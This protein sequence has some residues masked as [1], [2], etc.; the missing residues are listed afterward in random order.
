MTT[1]TVRNPSNPRAFALEAIP[2]LSDD[3]RF[4]LGQNAEGWPASTRAEAAAFAFARLLEHRIAEA[5]PLTPSIKQVPLKFVGKRATDGEYVT[6][7]RGVVSAVPTKAAQGSGKFRKLKQRAGG[8]LDVVF[9][10]EADCRPEQVYEALRQFCE[11]HQPNP[12]VLRDLNDQVSLLIL[13]KAGIVM[14]RAELPQEH[15]RG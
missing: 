8:L 7:G 6:V 3:S 4:A 15:L 10:D 1:T 2:A 9:L 13:L 11:D 14:H 5:P 12:Q